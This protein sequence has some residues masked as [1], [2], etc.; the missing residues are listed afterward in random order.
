MLLAD[1]CRAAGLPPPAANPSITGVAIDHRRVGAGGLFGAFPGAEVNGEDFI[2]AAI[3]AGA[4]AVVA[5]P[6]A[7]V[8]A[9]AVHIADP[10]PRRAFAALA[11]QF[12]APLPAMCAAVTGTNGKTSVADLARQL[13]QAAGH[14]AAA[15][16]TL[17]VT[18]ARGRSGGALTT[19]DIV[20]FL[21]TLAGLAANGI[22]HAVFEASSHGLDQYRTDGARV[23]AAAFTNLSHDHL[24]YHGTMDAYFAAK[25]RLFTDILVPGGT[26]VLWADDPRSADV[27]AA[28]RAA[29]RRVLSVG[30]SGADLRLI[31]QQPL[32]TGQRLTIGTGASEPMIVDLPLT[33]GYQGANALVAAGL[34][35]ASGG[36]MAAT[37]ANL[38]VLRP[39]P[40]RLE[41]AGVS[42][43]GA[44]VYV[45]YAHTPAA[46]TAALAALRPHAAGR[47]IAVIGA[48]GDRD[49]AKRPAMGSAAAAGAEMV[50][51]TDDNPRGEDPAAI[52]AAVLAGAPGGVDVAD[53]RAAIAA[54]IAAARAGDIVC[55]MGKG[56]E[57]G[58]MFGRGPDARTVPF[59]DVAAVRA[60]CA[61][62]I[63]Q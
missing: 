44:P 24:D 15:L 26:A 30:R 49:A 41:A 43:A 17:G 4:S 2:A 38:A 62:D 21:Q 18:T 9:A 1:L 53:R 54:A 14:D 22:S 39:V 34:V 7:S 57:S 45:D 35:V 12:I 13:W 31:A 8:A 56:H 3:A 11:G 60:I 63:C 59:D 55:V 23:E 52:R 48:G 50:V 19:P 33:G 47:L 46:I 37:L 51:V 20:T 40:G 28:A 10:Q 36:D 58:Q 42:A 16:G 5:R 25:L 29:G 61:E 6:G 32:P 27:A